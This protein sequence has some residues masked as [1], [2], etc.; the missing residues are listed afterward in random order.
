MATIPTASVDFPRVAV[1]FSLKD[2]R[3]SAA[4]HNSPFALMLARFMRLI[5][6]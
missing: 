6:E 2:E 5:P 4:T 3:F 1:K